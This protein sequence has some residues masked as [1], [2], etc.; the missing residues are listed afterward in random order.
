MSDIYRDLEE[1]LFDLVSGLHPDWAILMAYSNAAEPVNPYVVID[2]RKLTPI[3]REYTST[4][5]VGEDGS[6]LIEMTIQ[7]YEA[8]V[9]FEVIGKYDISR[10]VQGMAQDLNFEL[11]S[12][13]GYQLQAEHKLS[14]FNNT[15]L[16]RIPLV[17]DTD[18]Y[19]IYQIDCTFGYSA[20]MTTEQDYARGLNG[21]GV[22]HDANQPPDYKITTQLEVTLPPLGD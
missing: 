21:T 15:S 20:V 6:K 14:L 2:V 12:P 8:M 22:Y 18:V 10:N 3:G 11:R 9:R 17:R 4:P 13:K 5:T 1:S 7:D 19:M 16:R